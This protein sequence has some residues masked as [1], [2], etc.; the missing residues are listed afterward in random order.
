MKT[1]LNIIKWC[2]IY[3]CHYISCLIPRSKRLWLYS[4]LAGKFVDNAKYLFIYANK[5][6]PEIR[7]VWICESDEVINYLRERGYECYHKKSAKAIFL[8]LRASVQVYSS[9][10]VDICNPAYSGG[11]F[12]FNLWHGTPLKKI[13]YDITKGPIRYLYYPTSFCE[14]VKRFIYSP[15]LTKKHHAAIAASEK[16]K[17]IFCSAFRLKRENVVIGQHPRLMPFY[18]N[19]NDLIKHIH[20]F[21]TKALE[22]LLVRFRSYDKV[23]VYMPTW[24]DSNPEFLAQALPRFELLNKVCAQ[25]N[26]LF[27]LKTHI[28]TVF[29]E[30]VSMYSNIELVDRNIDMYPLL[31][32][33]QI[34]IT[35]YSSIFFDYALLKRRIIFYPYDLN[36]Y[37]DASREFYFSYDEITKGS[38]IAYD[39]HQLL[40]LLSE[41]NVVAEGDASCLDDYLNTTSDF[42]V[43]IKFIKQA[44]A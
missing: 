19:R 1:F 42:D 10:S 38:M 15:P 3:C 2:I 23:C 21:E 13:E 17:P 26:M 4:S 20:E 12:R 32:F 28:N 33:T 35:D 9:Y 43:T 16:L 25:N 7:H 29:N 34:L 39:F 30:D 36:E 14:K 27:L 11:V 24:R 6:N 8:S 41:N 5:S 44:I 18:W 22:N 37:L 40:D 31:P